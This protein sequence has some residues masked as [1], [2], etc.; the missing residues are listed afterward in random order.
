MPIIIVTFK[1]F[2]KIIL[3]IIFL[4]LAFCYYAIFYN[5]LPEKTRALWS[6]EE[7]RN[8]VK[9]D[10]DLPLRINSLLVA[11]GVFPRCLV[12]AGCGEQD[13]L[14]QFRVFEIEYANK[15]V[16]IDP[17]HDKRLHLENG[18]AG[19]RFY[20]KAYVQMQRAMLHADKIL[21]THEHYDHIGGLTESRYQQ[22]LAL[23]SV[24]TQEQMQSQAFG[25]PVFSDYLLAV[26]PLLYER[27][28]HV[29]DGM[30]LVKAP[31][32]TPGS[33]MIF[34]RL[35]DGR[36]V[37]FTGDTVWHSDNLR[38]QKSKSRLASLLGG[39]DAELLGSEIRALIEIFRQTQTQLLVAHDKELLA[40]YLKTGLLLDGLK[41]RDEP[42]ARSHN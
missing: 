36:E 21:F 14:F 28:F 29:D 15:T 1:R 22:Q 26:K 18:F 12:I 20:S 16:I 38:E 41:Q 33:Q 13:Y 40:H 42:L 9:D 34:V 25:K 7:L 39:E 35:Q 4:L 5:G 37:L 17:V 32:H 3:L 24:L 8:M 19:P 6:L 2:Y 30:V 11:E 27:Y 31:A 10:R 23:K